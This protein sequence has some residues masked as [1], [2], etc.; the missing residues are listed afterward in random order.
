MSNVY[1]LYLRYK[2]YIYTWN[3]TNN[4][5]YV[6]VTWSFIVLHSS[7]FHNM[8]VTFTNVQIVLCSRCNVITFNDAN[9]SFYTLKWEKH[10]FF[11]NVI[12]QLPTLNCFISEMGY[13]KLYRTLL[14]PKLYSIKIMFGLR[15]IKSLN[16]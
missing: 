7:K 5:E 15:R 4:K 10:K 11:F 13:D 2:S 6:F 8:R 3:I 1:I 16:H 12:L 9:I 14:Y